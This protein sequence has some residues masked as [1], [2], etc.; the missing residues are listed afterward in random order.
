M[1]FPRQR[2]RRLRQTEN[3]RKLVRETQLSP[4]DFIYP[5]FV[6]HGK[7]IKK[8]IPSMPGNYQQS[9]DNIVKDAKEAYSLGILAVILFGIPE[10]KDQ[11]GTEAYS[12]KGI[13][14]QAIKAIKDKTPELI[15]ITDVCLCEY[16]SHG[17][18][19]VIKN[20]KILN[21]PTLQLLA[22]EAVSHAKAGADI[23]AP[24]DMMDGRVSAI[25]N[26]LDKENF[27]DTPI[28]SYAAKYASSFYGPFR[29]AA[30]STPKFGD[31]R[32]YQMDPANAREAI[33]EV[34]LD[35][36]EGADIVMVK[37]A[38]SYLDI[39]YRVKNEFSLP[40]AAYNV[41]GE[42]SIIKAGAKLGW[43]DEKRMMIEVL[44]SIKRAGADLIL[45]YFA[46]EAAK[47]L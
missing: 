5:L 28:M 47:L 24:S 17:H 11:L 40:V 42:F 13:I 15:V 35:I 25:R 9:I 21:D 46:K 34:A 27:I 12:K 8:E 10:H 43:I 26:A 39:I 22:K 7:G 31:R 37:P 6:T 23:V 44:T 45:T 38:L 32:T 19:G 20:G 18:C 29:D 4:D 3:F 36:D 33:R 2:L 1:A 16:T 30:E 14:Q 41:S